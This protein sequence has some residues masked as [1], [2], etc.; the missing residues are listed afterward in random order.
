MLNL[1]AKVFLA[2]SLSSESIECKVRLNL[3]TIDYISNI[4]HLKQNLDSGRID[5][6]HRDENGN[7]A[8]HELIIR[9]SWEMISEERILKWT[10][11]AID[12]IYTSCPTVNVDML[13]SF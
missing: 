11:D 13:R 2:A 8:L 4:E 10:E 6:N 1:I 3:S 5:N 9:C 7:T 12:L